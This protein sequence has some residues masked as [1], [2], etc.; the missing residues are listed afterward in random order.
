MDGLQKPIIIWLV[1]KFPPFLEYKSSL[2]Y[3]LNPKSDPTVGQFD[4]ARSSSHTDTHTQNLYLQLILILSFH[5]QLLFN[6][7]ITS[8]RFTQF[9]YLASMH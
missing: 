1:G 8:P 2:S 7:Q 5:Q 9:L 4:S 6:I 3:S